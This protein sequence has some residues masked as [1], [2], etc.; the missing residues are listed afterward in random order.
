[1]VVSLVHELRRRGGGTGVAAMCAGPVK[2]NC[3]APANGHA[4]RVSTAPVPVKRS[5]AFGLAEAT[6]VNRGAPPKDHAPAASMAALAA[7]RATPANAVCPQGALL[8]TADSRETPAQV[9]VE[10]PAALYS[11]VTLTVWSNA[12]VAVAGAYA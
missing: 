12:T 4:V 1:M 10:A 8:H 11:A 7:P 9:Q 2:R 5:C 6:P 3:A